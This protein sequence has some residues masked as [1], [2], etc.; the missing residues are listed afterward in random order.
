MSTYEHNG[1]TYSQ[2]EN[3]K[4]LWSL[5]HFDGMMTGIAEYQGQKCFAKCHQSPFTRKD[6]YFWLYPLTYL[7]FEAETQY[8]DWFR[9]YIGFHCDFINNKRGYQPQTFKEKC[10]EWTRF[11]RNEP[12]SYDKKQK[13]LGINRENYLTREAIGYAVKE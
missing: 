12:I 10:W 8:Q 3:V 11:F 4:F 5:G 2:L 9:K 6:R 1:K 13:E 7:E